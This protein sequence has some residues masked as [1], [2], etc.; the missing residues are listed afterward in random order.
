MFKILEFPHAFRPQ[1]I[2]LTVFHAHAFG[3]RMLLARL[4]LDKLHE[5]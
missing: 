4:D 2:H 5:V 1:K 3:M